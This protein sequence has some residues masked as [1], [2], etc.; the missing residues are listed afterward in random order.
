MSRL[1]SFQNGLMKNYKSN[2]KQTLIKI[3]LLNLI[4]KWRK[5]NLICFVISSVVIHL[6]EKNRNFFF[7][8]ADFSLKRFSGQRCGRERGSQPALN[9]HLPT[10]YT[11]Y[12]HII[13]SIHTIQYIQYTLKSKC[14][15]TFQSNKHST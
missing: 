4:E 7:F 15:K 9:I 8:K 6:K 11:I 12:V 5:K 13:D 14:V 3:V 1:C 10:K 2:L